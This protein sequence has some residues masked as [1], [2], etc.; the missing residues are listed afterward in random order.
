MKTNTLTP[1]LLHRIGPTAKLVSQI[2]AAQP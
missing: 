2:T 1:E